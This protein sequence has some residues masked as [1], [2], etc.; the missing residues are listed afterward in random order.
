MH[1]VKNNKMYIWDREDRMNICFYEDIALA[2]ENRNFKFKK[3]KNIPDK[4]YTDIKECYIFPYCNKNLGHF[5]LDH[6]FHLYHRWMR[7]KKPILI[8]YSEFDFVQDFIEALIGKEW[9]IPT[10]RNT[11]Y[12]IEK[13][14]WWTTGRDVN[15]YPDCF[16]V[17]S[18]IKLR[19]FSSL[20]LRY[21]RK[22]RI[23]YDR[24]ELQLK[25]ILNVDE[26]F[27]EKHKLEKYQL[28]KLNFKDTVT[29]LAQTKVLVHPEGAGVFNYIFL[30][31]SCIVVEINCTSLCSYA[32]FG[33]G[34]LVKYYPYVTTNILE[35]D[36]TRRE[37]VS[38][39]QQTIDAH[40]LWDKN[41]EKFIEDKI[42]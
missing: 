22:K 15:V 40:I 25:N 31:P 41:I 11:V 2:G 12:K 17:L 39:Y 21:G 3:I 10:Q 27:L 42:G 8:N 4:Q 34:K 13:L 32:K 38:R 23:F 26:K 28:S 30:D 19:V 35:T 1:R 9:L 16:E 33:L 24:K 6:F 36:E 5:F 18:G 20:G 37:N 29:L 14:F 7:T